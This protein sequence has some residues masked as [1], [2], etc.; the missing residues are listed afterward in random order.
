MIYSINTE[1]V[2][3]RGDDSSEM[4]DRVS[5]LLKGRYPS[6]FTDQV[7]R[8]YVPA[9]TEWLP[10]ETARERSWSW[11]TT[12]MCFAID[13]QAVGVEWGRI[14]CPGP[15]ISLRGCAYGVVPSCLIPIVPAAPTP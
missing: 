1:L 9:P 15:S 3:I 12:T 2:A 4:S 5:S 14:F 8:T 11:G 7:T 10:R 6:L 13:D